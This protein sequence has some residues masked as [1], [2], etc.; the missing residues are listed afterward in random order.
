MTNHSAFAYGDEGDEGLLPFGNQLDELGLT[1][2]NVAYEKPDRPNVLY[3]LRG[4]GHG[5][6]LL[7]AAH[8]D[9]KPVG[10]AR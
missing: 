8:T 4:S 5:P 1:G 2:A 6:T 3:T 7:Y 10:D 9:T